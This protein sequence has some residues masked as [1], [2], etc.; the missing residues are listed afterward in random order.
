MDID[1]ITTQH[2]PAAPFALNNRL[3]GPLTPAERQFRYS[4]NLCIICDSKDHLKSICPRKRPNAHVAAI[5][6]P[7]FTPYPSTPAQS[8][9]NN[10]H[11]CSIHTVPH[12]QTPLFSSP[13]NLALLSSEIS[14]V[15]STTPTE[16]NY[17]INTTSAHPNSAT[18]ASDTKLLYSVKL[19]TYARAFCKETKL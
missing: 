15:P 14:S 5:N 9:P 6:V 13:I 18:T 17:E 4:N 16:T 7:K 11:L 2:R 10:L 3:R 19:T 1:A 12:S 8:D